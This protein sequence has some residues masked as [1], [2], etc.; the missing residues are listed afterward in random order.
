MWNSQ[1]HGGIILILWSYYTTSSSYYIPA[2]PPLSWPPLPSP[3]SCCQAEQCRSCS[4]RDANQQRWARRRRCR[5]AGGQHVSGLGDRGLFRNAS[6]HQPSTNRAAF[7]KCQSVK[8]LLGI[9]MI[10]Y[11]QCWVLS[12]WICIFHSIHDRCWFIV[13][14]SQTCLFTSS[15]EFPPKD[16]CKRVVYTIHAPNGRFNIS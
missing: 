3:P 11:C 5:S 2:I 12:R 7:A 16:C 13:D 1:N 4:L 8:R 6:L 10:H 9:I 15:K 14:P